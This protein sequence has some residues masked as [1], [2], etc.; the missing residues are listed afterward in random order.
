MNL[1]PEYDSTFANVPTRGPASSTASC[2]YLQFLKSQISSDLC[3]AQE[4]KEA[5]QRGIRSFFLPIKSLF[6]LSIFGGL[7]AAGFVLTVH[8]D[9][10][11]TC[12]QINIFFPLS[13]P[14]SPPNPCLYCSPFCWAAPPG[15]LPEE[16]RRTIKALCVF[17]KT[18]ARVSWNKSHLTGR[19]IDSM[20]GEEANKYFLVHLLTSLFN[21]LIGH[22]ERNRPVA[23]GNVNLSPTLAPSSLG[24]FFFFHPSIAWVLG[25]KKVNIPLGFYK[26]KF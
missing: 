20:M 5:F 26:A 10:T 16:L 17:A 3:H 21:I 22:A 19:E 4:H 8:I 23:R 14:S 2:L 24:I 18:S 12:N 7:T 6:S 25:E 11:R 9:G 15:L 13:L 1:T